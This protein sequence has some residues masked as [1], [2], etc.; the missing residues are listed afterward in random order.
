MDCYATLILLLFGF[1]SGS[2]SLIPLREFYYVNLAVNW[3]DAQHYCREK[4]TDLATIESMDDISRLKP[5][6]SYTWAWIGLKDDPES[7]KGDLGNDSNSWRWSTTGETSKTGYQS[8]DV[9]EPNSK[10]ANENCVLMANDGKWRDAN[11]QFSLSFVCYT[12]TNQNEK[13]Y[14]FIPDLKTWTSA[15]AYCRKH[16]TDLSMIENIVENKEVYSLKSPTSSSWIGLYREPWTWSDNSQSTFRSWRDT[17]PNNYYGNQFCMVENEQHKWDDANCQSKYPFICH[18]V[19]KFKTRVRMK[20]QTGINLTNPATSAQ[21][22]QQLGA[23]L[24]SQGWTDFSMRWKIQ[25][26]KQETEKL[27]E[28]HC[29]STF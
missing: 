19:S 18:Q 27:T 15:Q 7:W 17:S 11:C 2:G 22:L 20:I 23:V 12:V 1:S 26:R 8:W 28:H 9:N 13:I 10:K 25:S 4:Y 6:F 29:T 24:T 21:I 5:D 3:A 14:V 16:Y